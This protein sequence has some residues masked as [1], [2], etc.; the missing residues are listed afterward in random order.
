MFFTNIFIKKFY[1][2]QNSYHQQDKD[3]LFNISKFIKRS[4]YINSNKYYYKIAKKLKKLGIINIYIICGAH[5]KLDNYKTIK[6]L[7][8]HN[9]YI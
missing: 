6:S 5:I 1:D 4:R 8:K 9:F 3:N 2:N 7:R